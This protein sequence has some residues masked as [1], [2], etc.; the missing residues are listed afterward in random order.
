MRE[1]PKGLVKA[2]PPP[3][4]QPSPEQIAAEAKMLTA[5]NQSKSVE[6][7]AQEVAQKG[8]LEAR[9]QEAAEKDKTID[10]AKTIVAHKGDQAKQAHEQ[11]IDHA[12]HGLDVATAAHKAA[13]DT[14]DMVLQTAEAMK[15]EPTDDSGSE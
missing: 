14:H 15:P 13:I 11:T 8:Q 12:K 9:E 10:L 6:V 4:T 2:P 7:K 5:Q 1:D 3:S